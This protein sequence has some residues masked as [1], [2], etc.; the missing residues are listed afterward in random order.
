MQEMAKV[1]SSPQKK[2]LDLLA[3]KFLGF[4]NYQMT[5]FNTLLKEKALKKTGLSTLDLHTDFQAMYKSSSFFI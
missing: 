5:Y 1:M 3:T 4:N 2:Y